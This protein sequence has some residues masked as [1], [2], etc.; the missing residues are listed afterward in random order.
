MRNI[1][2]GTLLILL[3]AAATGCE[4]LDS[5]DDGAGA[6]SGDPAATGGAGAA[7]D[8][9]PDVEVVGSALNTCT[10]P[11]FRFYPGSSVGRVRYGVVEFHFDVCSSNAAESWTRLVTRKQTN[12]TGDNFG[13]FLDDASVKLVRSGSMNDP[14]RGVIRYATW[15]GRIYW[16]V[17]TPRIGWPCRASGSYKVNFYGTTWNGRAVVDYQIAEQPP[18]MP[19]YTTP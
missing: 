17:C 2:T 9:G 19:L 3:A 13:F 12:A 15:E 4:G 10:H 11:S 14:T 1:L 7:P 16:K 8:P 6:P 18:G 5:I